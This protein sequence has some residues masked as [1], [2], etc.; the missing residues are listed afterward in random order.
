MIEHG[1][2]SYPVDQCQ[3]ET[4]P[5]KKGNVNIIESEG[6]RKRLYAA[7]IVTQAAFIC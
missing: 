5:K 2:T 6:R 7:A 3:N 1:G 4:R